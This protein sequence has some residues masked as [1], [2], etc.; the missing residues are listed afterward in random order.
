MAQPQNLLQIIQAVTGEL[1]LVQPTQVI[2][3]T[4]L[5]TV[6]LYNLANREGDSLRRTHNWTALQSLFTLNVGAPT[7]TT[8]T[9]TLGSP[10]ISSIPSTAGLVAGLWTI[11]AAF[12][13]VAAR[14][15]S[16]DS[17]TQVTMDMVATANA[18]CNNCDIRARIHIPDQ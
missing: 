2:G 4:D 10:V 18:S 12:V 9:V 3:A 8:G 13:P 11:T 7:V 16:V 6:Q 15:L 17:S 14:I 1:G 5:Q